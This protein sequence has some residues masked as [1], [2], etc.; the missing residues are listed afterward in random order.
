MSL[1]SVKSQKHNMKYSQYLLS[2]SLKYNFKIGIFKLSLYIFIKVFGSLGNYLTSFISETQ[3]RKKLTQTE[4]LKKKPT[5]SEYKL[6]L[7]A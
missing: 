4:K 2:D 7:F 3:E 6:W 1:K 5:F